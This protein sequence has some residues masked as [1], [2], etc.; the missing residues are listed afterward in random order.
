MEKLTILLASGNPN[1]VREIK[2]IMA[3]TFPTREIEV[4]SLRDIGFTGDIVEDGDSFEANALIKAKAIAGRGYITMADDS[5]LMVDAL[6]GEP[7]VYSARYAGEPCDNEANNDK[8]LQNLADVPAKKRTA[9]FVSVV[10]CV[11]PDGR[12][13][14]T[15]GECPGSV[16]F[17]RTGNG[18]FGYDPLFYYEP[19]RKT[20]AQLTPEEKNGISHR[21]RAMA[22]F[23][24]QFKK[25]IEE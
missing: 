3:K 15:R 22:A 2:A 12:E 23:T 16:L 1:K 18:G 10:A 6:G 7:G 8:L 5:G 25:A 4:L 11:F 19:L 14:V 21:A 20:F 17:E 13:I 24:E 9:K